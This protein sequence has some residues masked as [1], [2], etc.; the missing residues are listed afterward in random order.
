MIV[1]FFVGGRVVGTL[2]V[3]DEIP[4]AFSV[5]DRRP[6]ERVAREMSPLYE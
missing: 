6:F 5:D 3:E 1:P 2:D 4:D